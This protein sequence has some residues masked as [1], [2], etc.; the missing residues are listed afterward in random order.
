MAAVLLVQV[1]AAV[2]LGQVLAVALL[3]QGSVAVPMVL[4]LVVLVLHPGSGVLPSHHHWVSAHLLPFCLLHPVPAAAAPA[5]HP[6]Y[7][8]QLVHLCLVRHR[9]VL[10]VWWYCCYF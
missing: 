8:L 1:L 2:P 5:L 7:P 3:V 10:G 6:H 9:W 4:V